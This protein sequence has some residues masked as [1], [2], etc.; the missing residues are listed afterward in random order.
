MASKL[1]SKSELI[2]KIA[3]EARGRRDRR[4]QRGHR[5]V[6]EIGYKELKKTGASVAPALSAKLE[7]LRALR[8]KRERASKSVYKRAHCSRRSRRGNH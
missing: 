1:M 4:R 6:V 7:S 2:Q 3:E 5:V 8:Q